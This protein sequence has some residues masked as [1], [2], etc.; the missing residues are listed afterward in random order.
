MRIIKKVLFF[1]ILFTGLMVAAFFDY[2]DRNIIYSKFTS[3]AE[4]IEFTFHKGISKH[5]LKPD[6]QR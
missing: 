3:H 4:R 5:T 2:S 6:W 1:V